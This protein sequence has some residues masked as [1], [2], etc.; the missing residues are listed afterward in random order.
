MTKWGRERWQNSRPTGCVWG[1]G[2]G[3][4]AYCKQ[5]EKVGVYKVSNDSPD[6]VVGTGKAS[7]MNLSLSNSTLP[8][9]SLMWTVL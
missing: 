6:H 3:S 5:Y 8:L 1:S 4:V 9:A 7:T 2:E